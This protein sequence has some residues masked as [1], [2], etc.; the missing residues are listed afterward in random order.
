MIGFYPK[1]FDY[2]SGLIN[3]GGS[4]R[5]KYGTFEAKVK[6]S[7]SQDVF[8]AFWLGGDALVPQIDIFKCYKNKLAMSTFWGNP[9]EPNGVKNDTASI[10]ASKFAEN[11][12]I[13][14]LEWS[15]EKIVWRINNVV[16]KTQTSNIPDQPLYIVLNSGVVGDQPGI[17]ARLEIDWVR[18]YQKN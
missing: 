14:S 4:F 1:D 6:M 5:T 11:Y 7:A 10:S 12:F 3:T 17:P 18:C 16:V 13:Y 9:A 2:T 15:P 8:H